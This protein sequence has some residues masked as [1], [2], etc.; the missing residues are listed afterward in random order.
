MKTRLLTIFVIGMVGLTGT[1]FAE[2]DP[3]QPYAHSIILPNDMKEKT[4][5]EFM[6]WCVPFYED[7]CV[8][9]EK[10]RISKILSP[11]MQF[12]SGITIDDIQCREPLILVTRHDGSPACVTEQTKT[13]LIERRW[14]QFQ[15][16]FCSADGFDSKGNLNK[17]NSTHNWA[18]N[19]CE[20]QHVDPVT[21]STGKWSDDVPENDNWCDTELIVKTKE[22]IDQ[23][24]LRL[25]LL[26]EIVKFGAAY[27][28]PDRDILLTDMGKNKTKISMNGSW[29]LEQGRPDI[30]KALA[31]LTFVDNVE[32]YHGRLLVVSC[33]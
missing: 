22:K 13:K 1:V 5:D 28:V 32:E 16:S 17:S 12:K 11:L 33:Q 6:T 31:E 3:N 4:F 23:E 27:D 7:K 14:T 30:V 20:W 15:F 8:K 2:H 21:N 19:Y 25:I 10:N 24:S 18:E 26:G 9:L 29:M